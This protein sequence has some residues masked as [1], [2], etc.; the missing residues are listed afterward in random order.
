MI[1]K[2]CDPPK[3]RHF[4]QDQTYPVGVVVARTLQSFFSE[5][6]G[7]MNVRA[8]IT[9]SQVRCFCL[10]RDSFLAFMFRWRDRCCVAC[11]GASSKLHQWVN[12]FSRE[13]A[14]TIVEQLVL[15]LLL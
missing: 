12:Q 13:A 9:L 3:Y 7:R 10:G 15:L 11:L 4:P 5:P 1:P 2:G 8:D 6:V 14:A